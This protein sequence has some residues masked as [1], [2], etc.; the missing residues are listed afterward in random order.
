[1]NVRRGARLVRVPRLRAVVTAVAAL[2]IIG[3][4]VFLRRYRG[5]DRTAMALSLLV[6]GGM[7]LMCGLAWFQLRFCHRV[8]PRRALRG[9]GL[10]YGALAGALTAGIGIVLLAVRW[11]MDQLASPVSEPFIVAF[12]RA[13]VA[14]GEHLAAGAVAYLAAGAMLGALV[15]FLIAEAIGISGDRIPEAEVVAPVEMDPVEASRV[16]R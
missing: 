13:L 8:V 10:R 4:T 16:E 1:M 3:L 7:W 12:W 11:A 6:G 9:I 15:G 14:L 2:V 5:A